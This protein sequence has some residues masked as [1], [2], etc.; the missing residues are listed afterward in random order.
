VLPNACRRVRAWKSK[1]IEQEMQQLFDDVFHLSPSPM[2]LAGIPDGQ[3]VDVNEAFLSVT[4]YTADE[5]LGRT[6]SELGLFTDPER[7]AALA[8]RVISGELVEHVELQIRCKDGTLRDGLFSGKVIASRG[9]HYRLSLMLDITERKAAEAHVLF[10]AQVLNSVSEA[11]VVTDLG[12][13]ILYW[14]RGAELMY[15][16]KSEEVLGRPYRKYAG[17]VDV[18]DEEAFKREIL[19]KGYWHGENMQRKRDGSTFWSAVHISVMRDADGKPTGFI[20]MDHDI[21]ERKRDEQE[22]ERLQAQ[23]LQA[24]KM[25]SIGRLAGGVAHDFNNLLMVIMGAAELCIQS[26]PPDDVIRK[27]L[28]EIMSAGERAA[29]LTRQLLAFARKQ[30]ISPKMLDVNSAVSGMLSLLRRLIGESI[31]LSWQPEKGLW[32]VRLD[33][34]QLDQILANLCI[35]ARDAISGNGKIVIATGNVV[36]GQSSYGVRADASPGA[37]VVLSVS[38]NG[39]GMNDE[40]LAYIF[41]PFYTTNF[42]S[43]KNSGLGLATV[44]GIARQNGGFIDVESAPE[45]GTTFRIHLPRFTGQDS[46]Q[47]PAIAAPRASGGQETLMLVE[48]DPSVCATTRRFLEQLGYTVLATCFPEEALHLSQAHPGDIALLITDVVMPGMS[49]RELSRRMAECRPKTKCLFISG[50]TADII[51]SQGVLEEGY[52]FLPKPFTRDSLAAKVRELLGT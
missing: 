14:G 43:N 27:D 26:A 25:E 28:E 20:G 52:S 11:V 8:R 48:D 16:Y 2:A 41:E 18:A 10:Q 21:S 47:A 24:Q 5:V 7:Q 40:A 51:A 35:N 13:T 6:A 9:K 15:G 1:P 23:L 46:S 36:V 30:V 33:P 39:S 31:E 29:V 37:Y 50:Y 12:G 44:Y 49:G 22:K 42:Q 4:G 45:Q 34:G 19:D 32:P 17:A 3:L 38:D